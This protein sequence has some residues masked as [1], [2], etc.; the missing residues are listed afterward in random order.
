MQTS[1]KIK[2]RYHIAPQEVYQ[3]EL[4]NANLDSVMDKQGLPNDPQNGKLTC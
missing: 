2:I 3:S 4:V 1:C